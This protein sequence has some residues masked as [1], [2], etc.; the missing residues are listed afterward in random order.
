MKRG[1][2]TFV[3]DDG[4][5]VVYRQVVPLLDRY[6]MPGVFA[7]PLN[8]QAVA[9]RE[10]RP[11]VPWAAWLKLNDRHEIAAHSVSHVNL[12]TL[13]GPTLE[14]ELRLPAQQLQATTLVYPGGAF[15]E[16]VVAAARR[17]FRAGRTVVRGLEQLPP[18]DPMR[19][20]TINFTRRNFSVWRANAWVVAALLTGSWLIETYHL[21]DDYEQEAMHAVPL[22]DFSRHVAFVQRLGLP[23]Q[24]IRDTITPVL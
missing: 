21:V 8:G 9:E 24:T 6:G 15:D 19:L 23:V 1:V 13:S 5:D 18:R 16:A 12:T 14:D 4:Y 2:V 20:H 7:V 3:F 11:V 17:Y 22:R 10:R